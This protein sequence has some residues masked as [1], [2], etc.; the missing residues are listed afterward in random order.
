MT[1]SLGEVSIPFNFNA[2]Q[3]VVTDKLA[4]KPGITFIFECLLVASWLQIERLHFKGFHRQY[5]EVCLE[6]ENIA[7]STPSD[8]SAKC[9]T[10]CCQDPACECYQASSLTHAP[11]INIGNAFNRMSQAALGYKQFWLET[12]KVSLFYAHHHSLKSST[13]HCKRNCIEK[14]LCIVSINNAW[15]PMA[16]CLL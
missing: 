3:L 8:G 16:F 9:I 14:W 13:V 7:S 10:F 2:S 6:N 4:F 1:S 15:W 12:V 5:W 11:M